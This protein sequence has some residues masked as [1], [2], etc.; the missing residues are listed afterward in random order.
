MRM[1]RTGQRN[2]REAVRKWGQVLLQFMWRPARRDEMNLVEVKAPV[3]SARDCQV[4]RM[5]GIEGA[6]ENSNSPGMVFGRGAVSLRCGQCASVKG[7]RLDSLTK[8]QW[9]AVRLRWLPGCQTLRR[10]QYLQILRLRRELCLPVLPSGFYPVHQR[11]R[12]QDS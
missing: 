9:Q 7:T 3:G 2:H 11:C 8:P 10:L 6:T 1:V 4:T 12:E 5:D